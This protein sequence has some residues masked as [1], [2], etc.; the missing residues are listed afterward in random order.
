[1]EEDENFR[2][3]KSLL[4]KFTNAHGISGFEHDI[5][6]LLK[7]ELEPYVDNIRKDC[8]GNLIAVKNGKGPSIMLAAH[9][10][11]IGL[12]V[13]YIDDNG[14]LRFI[15]IGGWFDQTL[16]NQRVM[17]HGKKGSIPGVIG[18]KPPHVMKDEDRKKPIKLDDMFIDI[19]AKNREDAENLGIEIGTTASID[20]DFVSLANGKVTSKAFDDRAGLAILVEVMKR[21]SKHK[22]E[23]NVYAVG[24]VQE[25]VGLK[26]AKTCAFGVCPS[27]ALALDTTIPGDHPGI[28][29]TDSSLELGKGPVITVA[30]ASGRGLLVHPQILKWLRETAAENNIPYQLGVGSGGTT[31]ATSIHL[32]KEGIPTGTVSIATR[33]I[34]SPVEVLDM[35]DVEACVS[36]I[37]KAIENVG[38]YF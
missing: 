22:I 32:T 31:D 24:T 16:L 7:K 10:D 20:R 4:E 30:D 26:G 28:T 2:D 13:R 38:K 37:V 25:E 21:L 14:F 34:H 23:A 5:R 3:I 19:G 35:A 27:I 9:M 12:M 36:L 33:Y 15:G 29:K 1:M 8:M 11:E 18:S 6:E 17:V